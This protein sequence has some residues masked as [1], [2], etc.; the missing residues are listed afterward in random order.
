P[1]LARIDDARSDM[2]F[3]QGPF[4][5][6]FVGDF[7]DP[8]KTAASNHAALA[9]LVREQL[10]CNKILYIRRRERTLNLLDTAL[11][12]VNNLNDYHPAKGSPSPPST[13]MQ[14]AAVLSVDEA[15]HAVTHA[16]LSPHATHLQSRF[17]VDQA[18][19]WPPLVAGAGQRVGVATNGA[20]ALL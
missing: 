8:L 12:A 10:E 14:P 19:T 5:T 13:D 15:A 7:L 3:W 18:E 20:L 4:Q 11:Q 16:V 9:K 1:A 17:P 2:G 6:N